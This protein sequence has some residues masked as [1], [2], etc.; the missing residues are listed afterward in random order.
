MHPRIS[1]LAVI[2]VLVAPPAARA[3]RKD[4][5]IHRTTVDLHAFAWALGLLRQG[6]WDP[7][8]PL[9]DPARCQAAIERGRSLGLVDDDPLRDPSFEHAPNGRSAG[10]Y[11]YEIRFGQAPEL[12][13]AYV[14]AAR[15]GVL[16]ADAA[17]ALE[18]FA[19]SL[20][21]MQ[22]VA[23]GQGGADALEALK[24][25][26]AGCHVAV[27]RVVAAGAR[28]DGKVV[29]RGVERTLEKA[30]QDICGTLAADVPG[31][32]ARHDEAVRAR[33]EQVMA[34]YRAAGIAGEKL[35]L[36]ITYDG[37]FW[38]GI[39]G[40]IV[41]DP[42]KISRADVL[43]QWLEDRDG[44]HVI[45]RYQFSGNKLVRKTEKTYLVRPGSDAFR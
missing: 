40:D 44:S 18:P 12:C 6:K 38:R 2:A 36:I 26:A 20:L 4:G 43:F 21:W 5:A 35:E 32:V 10:G 27:E 31:Y 42:G 8:R 30:R 15:P 28:L 41:A 25:A 7:G 33:R 9:P 3:D 23:P 22:N 19:S 16:Q 39:G 24:K 13:S 37:V 34:P 17:K 1:A 29:V 11:H 45:R 14:A